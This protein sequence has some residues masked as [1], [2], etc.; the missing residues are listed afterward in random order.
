MGIFGNIFGAGDVIKEGFKLI[1]SIHTS[2]EEEIQA[3]AKAKTDLLTAYAPFKIAQR[4]LAFMFTGNFIV[5]FWTAVYLWAT[6]KDM[7][8]FIDIMEAFN[9]GWI[10]TAIVLFYFGG[11][12]FEGM[13][14]KVKGK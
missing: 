10:M 13:A 1:D 9:L 14:A 5:G 12:A 7:A 11:G 6:D 3:N 8:G 4:Y 2:D